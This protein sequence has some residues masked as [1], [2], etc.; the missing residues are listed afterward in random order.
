MRNSLV[1]ARNRF[2]VTSGVAVSLGYGDPSGVALSGADQN[3]FSG[4]DIGHVVALNG[5]TIAPGSTWRVSPDG[6]VVLQASNIGINGRLDLQG[7]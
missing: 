4:S 6:G 1:L 5:S 3:I 2:A 7:A